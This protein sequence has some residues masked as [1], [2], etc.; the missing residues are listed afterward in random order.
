MRGL[1]RSSRTTP[2]RDRSP[3]EACSSTA[4][5][6]ALLHALL[7]A[8]MPAG[9]GLICAARVIT[10]LPPQPWAVSCFWTFAAMTYVWVPCSYPTWHTWP[11]PPR[12]APCLT[13]LC[14]VIACPALP[15]TAPLLPS[16]LLFLF[17]SHP[18]SPASPTRVAHSPPAISRAVP[19]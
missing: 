1:S 4:R 9:P 12:P 3:S 6:R 7:H 15:S 14:A 11:T 16:L 18:I 5:S 10:Q 2:R 19:R 13:V 17:S 8:S